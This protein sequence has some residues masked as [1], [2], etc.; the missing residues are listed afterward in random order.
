MFDEERH[1]RK[2]EKMKKM[3]QVFYERKHKKKET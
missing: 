1:E 3:R 2:Q